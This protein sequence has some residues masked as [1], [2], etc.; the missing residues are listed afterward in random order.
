MTTT[1][2][3]DN[4]IQGKISPTQFRDQI[5]INHFPNPYMYQ[6]LRE[7]IGSAEDVQARLMALLEECH[8]SG[9]LPEDLDRRVCAATNGKI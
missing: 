3:V 7:R 1:E 6:V 9:E 4:F 2:L 5:Y 8:M